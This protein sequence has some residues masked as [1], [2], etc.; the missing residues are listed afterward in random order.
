[1]VVTVEDINDN[2]PEFQQ[3]FYQVQIPASADFN[4]AVFQVK[5]VLAVFRYQLL[6][7]TLCL[8]FDIYY[9]YIIDFY[10][11]YDKQLCIWLWI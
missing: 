8:S 1:M 4:K 3:N 2:S 11:Y 7:E 5:S 9:V 6:Q 10:M